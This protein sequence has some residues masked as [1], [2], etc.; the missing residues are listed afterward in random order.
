[1]KKR[2]LSL[3]CAL[4]VLLAAI[5]AVCA[6]EGEAIRASDTLFTLGLIP[7]AD[8]EIKA[9]AARG[10]AA[11]LLV[12]L[13]GPET[14]EGITVPFQ[15]VPQ[16]L[17]PYI[18]YAY[19]RGWVT[20]QTNETFAPAQA[21]DSRAWFTM[22]LRMLGYDDSLGDFAFAD[23]IAFARRIGLTS[24]AYGET[25]NRGDLYESA[26]DTLFFHFRD[27]GSTVLSRLL[28]RG[29]CSEIT[30]NALGLL[31]PVLTARQ[32]ADRHM[33]AVFGMDLYESQ[34]A[35]NKGEPSA[36]GSGFFITPDGVAVTCYHCLEKEIWAVA[37][38][39]TGESYE[40][41]RVLWYNAEMDLAIIRLSRTSL[42]GK[43][44]SAFSYLEITGVGDAR[45]GDE[46]Y[47]LSNPLGLGLAISTGVISATG[48]EVERYHFPCV[49]NTADISQGSSGGALLNVYGH[50]VAVTSGAY[51]AG[52]S[53]YLAIPADVILTVDTHV[54]GQSLPQIAAA[55]A[56]QSPADR[57]L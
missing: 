57:G 23:A 34:E 18:G 49:M 45:P 5:P 33:A 56:A 39:V 44:T 13:S 46:I 41:E 8:H 11:R 35:I 48:R 36:N 1:M 47:T 26:L 19:Q 22:L 50:V 38:L 31:N 37:T 53:M 51:R 9:P 43:V 16:E 29:L 27:S 2:L 30:A 55:T 21:V 28:A 4:A 17:V 42:T 15:D 12:K 20:G 7:Q 6:L 14:L 3:L 54:A 10:D 40:V 52:N 25:L 24:R 32:A